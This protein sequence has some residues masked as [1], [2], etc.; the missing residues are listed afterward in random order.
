MIEIDNA[1]IFIKDFENVY[2]KKVFRIPF[3]TKEGERKTLLMCKCGKRWI[4]L[5][6]FSI[7]ILENKITDR[8]TAPFKLFE[9]EDGNIIS[10]GKS[11]WEIRDT[12]GH[13]QYIYADK[14]VPMMKIDDK[15]NLWDEFPSDIKRKIRRAYKYNIK[16]EYGTSK[17]FLNKFY[18]A[19]AQR[20]KEIGVMTIGK[21]LINRQLKT[22]K[23]TVFV[24]TLDDKIIGGGTLRNIDGKIFEN[25]LFA[26]IEKYNH[27]YTSYILHYSMM[28]FAKQ[29]KASLYSFGRSTINS[30]VHNYKKHWR[31]KEYNIY[32]SY[33]K[34]HRNIR[35]KKIFYTIY[36]K[37][38]YSISSLFSPI[39]S[40]YIY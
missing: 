7:A 14:V 25:E 15:E 36:R 32:W 4:A 2:R 22:G 17:K 37:I 19:Y 6:Y 18:K 23:T 40:K 16:V 20:M 5:P 34:K 28:C 26:T 21:T 27:C 8:H 24:A 10:T 3:T 29:E 1:D 11:H 31:A 9:S 30:S 38:P 12:I 35:D 39:L 13:S 33:S